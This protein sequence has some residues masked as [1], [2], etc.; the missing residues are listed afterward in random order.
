MRQNLL[1]ILLLVFSISSAQNW[2]KT[3]PDNIQAK[4]EHSQRSHAQLYE[5]ERESF[6]RKLIHIPSRHS[7]ENGK[8]LILPNAQ[9]YLENF[10]VWEASN[11]SP[12]TQSKFPMIRSFVGKSIDDPSAYLRFS[13]GPSGITSTIFR[14]DAPSEYLETYSDDGRYFVIYIEKNNADNFECKTPEEHPKKITLTANDVNLKASDQKFRTYRLALS[15]TGEY[16]QHFGGTILKSLEAMNNTVTRVNALFE[17]DMSVNFILADNI[18]QLI[19]LDPTTDPYSHYNNMDNWSLELQNYLTNNFGND[20][21]DLG[22]LL[23]NDG[24]GGYA[25]CIGCICV[26]PT[27]IYHS[28]KGSAFS[29][30]GSGPPSGDKFDIDYVAHEIGHQVGANHTFT[31]RNEGSGVQVEPGGGSTIMAYAGITSFN[32]QLNSDD[33]FTSRNVQQIQNNL[34]SKTA[35]G[36][37][38]PI[39][40]TPPIITLA[41]NL[42]TIPQGT[43]FKLDGII[44]DS[45]NNNTITTTWEQNNSGNSSTTNQNSRVSATKVIG[46]NFRSFKP[47]KFSYR[48]FPQFSQ[49]LKGKLTHIQNNNS[50]WESVTTVPR[51]FDFTVT[52]RD[53]AALGPQTSFKNQRVQVI[54]AGPFIINTPNTT[55]LPF[56]IQSDSIHITWNIADTNK[57]PINTSKLKASISWNN[58]VTFHPLG[59]VDNTGNA[60][61]VKP[62]TSVVTTQGFIMLEAV[63]NIFLAVKQFKSIN[64]T[65]RVTD[66][67]ASKSMKIYP[68]PTSNLFTISDKL[69]KGTITIQLTDFNGRIV[70]SQT[71]QHSGGE[72]NQQFSP[73]LAKGTYLILVKSTEGTSHSKLIIH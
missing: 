40:N 52:A 32:V 3:S 30:P 43:A 22:H 71:V 1:L 13:T 60:R 35:C 15:V 69:S 7:G 42:Y 49:I 2:K 16:S 21:Y 62:P 45:E 41:K 58:G 14:A 24:G 33:Y 67:S 29:A 12:T 31:F 18:E 36:T 34:A 11:F 38:T 55:D 28:A 51:T 6:N 53:N 56:N 37:V 19:F 70:F 44:T 64:E 59:I 63:D 68:N 27:S 73:H 17:K 39:V 5:L 72:F 57:A 47:T 48:Y 23:S 8:P 54:A 25:G 4:A 26:N 65:F 10:I 9:G 61:F 50:I 46:P 66:F 20:N